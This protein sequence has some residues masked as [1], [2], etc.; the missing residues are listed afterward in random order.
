[1]KHNSEFDVIL[2]RELMLIVMTMLRCH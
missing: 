2:S 1:M